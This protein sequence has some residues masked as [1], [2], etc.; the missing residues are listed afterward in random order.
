M[1]LNDADSPT[2]GGGI[3]GEGGVWRKLK[4]NREAHSSPVYVECSPATL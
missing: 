3:G 1:T 4:E 2:D